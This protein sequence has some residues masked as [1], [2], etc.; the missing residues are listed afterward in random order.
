MSFCTN[1]KIAEITFKLIANLKKI[2]YT[3]PVLIL[4]GGICYLTSYL[5]PDILYTALFVVAGML[6]FFVF[7]ISLIYCIGFFNEL[8]YKY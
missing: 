3:T 8:V 5:N 4:L 1:E 6:L 2:L 7:S